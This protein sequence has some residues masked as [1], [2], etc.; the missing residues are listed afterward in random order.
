MLKNATDSFAI[1]LDTD[2][3][4]WM[5][6]GATATINEAV[7]IPNEVP[8]GDYNLYLHLPD[9]SSALKNNPRYAVRFAN[10]GTWDAKS[11]MNSLLSSIHITEGSEGWIPVEIEKEPS[12]SRKII[13]NGQLFILRGD[14]IYTVQGQEVYKGK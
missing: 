2:P 13:V 3:R 9:A 14:R 4:R 12:T 10:V 6:N 1:R 8:E 5:P 11:G 7:L